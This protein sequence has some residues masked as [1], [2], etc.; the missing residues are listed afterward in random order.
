MRFNR[1]TA[2]RGIDGAQEELFQRAIMWGKAIEARATGMHNLGDVCRL[3]VMLPLDIK[4]VRL[5][6]ILPHGP[7]YRT[8]SVK[9]F[10][11][12]RIDAHLKDGRLVEEQLG[13]ANLEN[14]P[15]VDNGYA[16]AQRLHVGKLV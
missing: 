10:F 15:L 13:R 16:V 11:A 7:R 9:Q 1:D 6:L 14:A 5:I 4:H 12:H 8:E 3:L 2:A